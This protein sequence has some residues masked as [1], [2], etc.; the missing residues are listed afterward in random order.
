M[1]CIVVLIKLISFFWFVVLQYYRFKLSGRT[2][3]GKFRIIFEEEEQEEE[4]TFILQEQ[5]LWFLVFVVAQYILF[6]MSRLWTVVLQHK[7]TSQ[8]DK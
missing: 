3:S 8:R 7:M 2:C 6:F 4:P 5:G 1:Q